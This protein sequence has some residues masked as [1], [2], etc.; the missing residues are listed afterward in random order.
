MLQ[1]AMLDEGGGNGVGNR[2]VK[3]DTETGDRS[4]AVRL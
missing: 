1:S 2:I 4:R 3:F